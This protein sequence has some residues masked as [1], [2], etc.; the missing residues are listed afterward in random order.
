MDPLVRRS[1]DRLANVSAF[2]DRRVNDTL[3]D[4]AIQGQVETASTYW[5]ELCDMSE[6][7][8]C[9]TTHSTCLT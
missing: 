7:L 8:A 5:K 2:E 6:A 3:L 9:P 4:G 1:L